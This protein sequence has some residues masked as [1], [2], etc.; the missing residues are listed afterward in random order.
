MNRE[1]HNWYSQRL[2]RGMDLLLFGHGG[3][4]T[5]VFPSS[6]GRFFEYEDRGMV[7]ALRW[8]LDTGQ[9]MLFCVDSVDSESWYNRGIHPADR[10]RRHVQYEEYL[11]NEVLPLMRSRTGHHRIAVT[12][13]SFGGYHCTNFALRHPDCVHTCVSMSGAYD[14]KSFLDG[15]YDDTCYFNNP[16]DFVPNLS[17][18]WYLDQYRRE[19]RWVFGAGEHDICLEANR[20]IS[21][22]FDAKGI[23]HWFDF[24]GLGAVHDWPLWQ[25]MSRKYLS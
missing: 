8:Q 6:M 4:P 21:A 9:R 18:A 1:Y 2:G 23:P 10:A 12:G 19:I 24:W 25:L 13:C 11:L 7:E 20:R 3:T 16:V 14:I 17:D 22:I 5:L 15:Y